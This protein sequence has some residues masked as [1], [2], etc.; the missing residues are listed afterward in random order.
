VLLIG[1]RGSV[2][3]TA[4]ENTL[5]SVERAL[6]QGADGVEVDVRITADGIPVCHH[7]P[8][9]A[10]TAGDPRD[11]SEVRCAELPW[12]GE[13]RVPRLSEVL[14]LVAGRGHLV[15]ELKTP[16]WPV[17]VEPVAAVVAVL[18]RHR[19]DAVTVS[20]F[21]RLRLRGVLRERTGAATALLGR[22]AV[23]ML[24]LLRQAVADGHSEVH[25]HLSS[26]LQHPELIRQHPQLRVTPWT[27]D[28]PRDLVGLRDAGAH[29]VISDDPAAARLALP[30]LAR[31]G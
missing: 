17:S 16:S 9:F 25:P 7:D 5:A 6:R 28:R 10:R 24:G 3:C 22:P 11:V 30:V 26:V 19:L 4:P 18:R 31:T 8:G 21:D 23:P 12:I 29:A 15:V 1:H 20:S 27:V 14:E 2:H 13:H